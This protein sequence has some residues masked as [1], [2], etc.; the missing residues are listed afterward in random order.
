MNRTFAALLCLG[1][2]AGP[3][4]ANFGLFRRAAPVQSYYPYPVTS[5]YY[6]PAP[7]YYALP[8]T[9]FAPPPVAVPSCLPGPAVSVGPPPH[10][11]R[12]FAV[13]ESAPPSPS[14]P[15]PSRPPA[16]TAFET[17][18]LKPGVPFFS[19]FPGGDAGRLSRSGACTVTFWN[20]SDSS[21]TL[22]VSGDRRTLE[23]RRSLTLELDRE[24]TWQIDG[25]AAEVS[26]A[27][28]E[29][30]GVTVVIRQ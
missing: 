10:A 20:L 22:R 26:R 8:P 25:R 2:A 27:P 14:G 23:R 17:S 18:S 29:E 28:T 30:G 12:P 3:A 6:A 11:P 16:R 21:L 4:A 15:L 13:P 19:I 9:Y 24:F 7:V 5:Y 1:L